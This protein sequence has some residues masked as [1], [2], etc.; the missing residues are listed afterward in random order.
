MR[1]WEKQLI[2][3][4]CL[5]QM[6]F[7]LRSR[8]LYL[9]PVLLHVFPGRQSLILKHLN[10][11]QEF[12]P[13]RDAEPGGIRFSGEPVGRDQQA[14]PIGAVESGGHLLVPGMFGLLFSYPFMASIKSKPSLTSGSFHKE[15]GLF[16]EGG[17]LVF[18]GK[19][20]IVK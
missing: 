12:L 9:F 19:I 11:L 5:S 1:F 18:D 17:T 8:C 2:C 15:G 7:Y 20:A 6:S 13:H 10:I 14:L 16:Y 3:L 4:I